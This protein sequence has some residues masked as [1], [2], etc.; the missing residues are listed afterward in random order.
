MDIRRSGQ[1]A[2]RPSVTSQ[3]TY[4][5]DVGIPLLLEMLRRNELATTFFVPGWVAE[6]HP[7]TVAAIC[8]SGHE[9]GHHGYLH[10]TMDGAT[11][12]REHEVLVEEINAL[13]RV[14]GLRPTGYRAPLFDVNDHTWELLRQEGFLYSSNLMNSIWPTL[15]VGEPPLVEIP[16]QWL[17]DDAQYYLVKRYP[18][19]HRQPCSPGTVVDIWTRE[20]QATHALGGATTIAL[21]PQLSGRP[22]R[23]PVLQTLIDTARELSGTWD[24]DPRRAGHDVSEHANPG[25][26][27]SE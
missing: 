5:I 12:E 27:G 21:H 13:E 14:S 8:E 20:F 24:A 16:V 19:N 18:P 11:R 9:I 3:A 25:A 22:S 23:I 10:D 7:Q 2:L 4:E 26:C 1:C 6:R 17:L 15:H